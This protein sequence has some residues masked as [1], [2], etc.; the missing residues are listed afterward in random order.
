[1]PG[2]KGKDPSKARARVQ[3][4][5][6]SVSKSPADQNAPLP[7]IS[8]VEEVK[9]PNVEELFTTMEAYIKAEDFGKVVA[10]ADESILLHGCH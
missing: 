4:L 6:A 9:G 7:E 1:M 3:L 10:T 5:G 8:P 2:G